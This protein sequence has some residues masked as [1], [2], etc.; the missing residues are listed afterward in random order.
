MYETFR[1]MPIHHK[2]HDSVQTIHLHKLSWLYNISE[3]I[4]NWDLHQSCNI[5]P[6]IFT[7]RNFTDFTLAKLLSAK[8]SLHRERSSLYCLGKIKFHEIFLQYK[9]SWLWRKLMFSRKVYGMITTNPLTYFVTSQNYI[10]EE[11]SICALAFRVP[12]RGRY[13]I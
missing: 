6:E 12:L 9:S 10:C 3:L 11:K 8:F 1:C 5:Q 13:R 4:N 7:R 2:G